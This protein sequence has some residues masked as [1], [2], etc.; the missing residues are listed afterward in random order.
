MRR[1][2]SVAVSIAVATTAAVIIVI[3]IVVVV[4]VVVV[5]LMIRS[6]ARPSDPSMEPI[7]DMLW[8]IVIM[9]RTRPSGD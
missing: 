3:I 9:T 1:S 2:K 7:A 6:H 8:L 5:T 4:V